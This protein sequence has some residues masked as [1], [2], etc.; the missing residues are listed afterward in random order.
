MEALDRNVSALAARMPHL[1]AFTE[2][3]ATGQAQ[4]FEPIVK[5]AYRA[6]ASREDLL[7]AVE[8]GR[9]LGTVPDPVIRQAYATIHAWSWIAARRAGLPQEVAAAA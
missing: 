6:G 9:C 2:G 1:T 4:R 3:V 7:T 5:A 8:V